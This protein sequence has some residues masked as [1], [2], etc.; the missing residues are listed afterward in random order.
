MTL[1]SFQTYMLYAVVV[2]MNYLLS[3]IDDHYRIRISKKI[4]INRMFTLIVFASMFIL[5]TYRNCGVDTPTYEYSFIHNRS[6][7]NYDIVFFS[8]LRTVRSF[9]DN[10][11]V[12]Q[13][14]VGGISLL[15]IWA[16]SDRLKD[17]IDRKTFILYS[18][19]YLYF[20][21]F[22]YARMMLS[23]GLLVFGLSYLVTGDYLKYVVINIIAG[24]IH[25]TSF[26][27][28]FVFALYYFGRRNR[29]IAICIGILGAS[30]VRIRPDLVSIFTISDHYSNYV[31]GTMASAGG[32]G[33]LVQIIP[34]FL[35]IY[36]FKKNTDKEIITLMYILLLGN[37]A[38]G[39]LGYSI[40]VASR[41]ARFTFAFP[42]M[43]VPAYIIKCRQET[44]DRNYPIIKGLSIIWIFLVYFG[45]I[46]TTFNTIGIIP[47]IA[48]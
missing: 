5:V 19:V 11:V 25:Y 33:T 14:V 47:Y 13:G 7:S 20:F 27:M 34:Y 41:I 28:L 15:G 16:A 24:L 10:I 3:G 1:T 23:V 30:L 26:S 6:D 36:L 46:Q 17:V 44:K 12:W 21:T 48:R 9:T 40:P 4:R 39:F 31:T 22:N 29:K 2:S 18:T 32:V 43:F 35:M 8:L 45:I 42:C 38:F 37:L